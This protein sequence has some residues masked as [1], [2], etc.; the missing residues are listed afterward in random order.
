M[1][2]STG[3]AT[4]TLKSD[5]TAAELI[6]WLGKR[7]SN[8]TITTHTTPRDRPFDSEYTTITATWEEED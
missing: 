7:P 8:A 2:K 3:T 1:A 5:T 4:L 6:R